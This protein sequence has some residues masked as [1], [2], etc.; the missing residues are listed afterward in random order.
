MLTVLETE[1]LILKPLAPGMERAMIE[2]QQ[3]NEAHFSPWN[4][5]PVPG[6]Y[7][8][9]RWTAQCAQSAADFDAGRGYRFIVF[10]RETP[11]EPIGV[12]NYSQVSRGPFQAC[13]LGYQIA[14]DR[15]GKGLMRE[16]LVAGNRFIFETARLHRIHANYVPANIRSGRLLARLGF[17][18]E[19]YAKEYLFIDG[20]WQDHVLTSLTHRRF[21]SGGLMRK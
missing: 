15:E 19:G 12:A 2:Y 14:S 9:E 1:R 3:A 4:P 11:H 6:E 13:F 10:G 5:P 8:L 20:A 17:T 21:D 16:A 18:I 7:S